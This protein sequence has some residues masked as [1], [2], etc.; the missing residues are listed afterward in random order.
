MDYDELRSGL[1][2]EAQYSNIMQFL[3]WYL[4]IFSTSAPFVALALFGFKADV[5]QTVC[6]PAL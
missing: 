4:S 2:K 6:G 3:N 1:R 5:S